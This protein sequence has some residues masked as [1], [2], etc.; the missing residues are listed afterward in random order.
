MHLCEPNDP[1]LL[2]VAKEIDRRA[3]VKARVLLDEEIEAFDDVAF[4][5][6]MDLAHALDYVATL[7][8][9]RD[10]IEGLETGCPESA[11]KSLLS[12]FFSRVPKL[13]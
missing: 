3:S 11:S 4:E 6:R 5:L 7:T 13:L 9:L 12:N 8:E 10:R 2:A 1:P